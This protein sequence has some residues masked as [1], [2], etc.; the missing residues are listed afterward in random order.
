VEVID[1]DGELER[2]DVADT[3]ADAVTVRLPVALDVCT[4]A[5]AGGTVGRIVT[6]PTTL[7]PGSLLHSSCGLTHDAGRGADAAC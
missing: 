7:E 3:D 4:G 2:D 5:G 1:A 6:Y